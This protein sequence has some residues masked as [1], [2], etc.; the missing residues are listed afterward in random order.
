MI[1]SHPARSIT[2][3]A[4]TRCTLHDDASDGG[5]ENVPALKLAAPP[6]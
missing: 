6:P 1:A 2:L 4:R 3:A 5:D